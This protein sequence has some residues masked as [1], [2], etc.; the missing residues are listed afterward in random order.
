M[1]P[2][3]DINRLERATWLDR[4]AAAARTLVQRVLRNQRVKDALHGVWLGHPL[5]PGAAQ[6]ALGSFTSAAVLDAV[7]GP[8]SGSSSLIAAGLVAT[9]PTVAS[10]WADYAD[11]HEDQ[12]RV[13]LVHAAT[14]GTAVALFVT[15]LVRRANGRSGRVASVAGGAVA[16]VGALLGG[17]LGYRQALGANHAEDITHIGPADWQ[18]LGPLADLPEGVPLRRRAGKVDVVV[19]RRGG[20]VTVLANRCSH[21]SAPLSEGEL[22]DADGDARI[23]C[24]WHGSQFRL[25][26][27]CVVHGP[28]TAS[29]PRFE[30]RVIGQ[31]VETRVVP[32]PGVDATP[33]S[34][35]NDLQHDMAVANNADTG[36]A[37]HGS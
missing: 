9:L 24:P 17:H 32:I 22:L 36:V 8:K 11:A 3:D 28:A 5:H 19:V 7:R 15:A 4:P 10:G 26:D 27:G 23:V 29:A 13:G 30:T 25:A 12:Q 35:D 33:D 21:L 2:F 16:G 14:N 1:R 20:D 18:P 37:R 31:S 6:F 34:P